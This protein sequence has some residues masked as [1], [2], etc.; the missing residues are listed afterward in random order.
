MEGALRRIDVAAIIAVVF[1][2]IVLGIFSAGHLK[3]RA[4]RARCAGNL[5]QIGLSLQLYSQDYT[6]LLPDCSRA[7]PQLAGAT[8]PLDLN[9]N[10]SSLLMAKGVTR[11]MFYCPANPQMNDDRHWNFWKQVPGP[12]R[13][14]GYG[15]LF[16]GVQQV[17]PTLWRA[18]FAG[19][20]GASPAEM[21]LGFDATASLNDDYTAITGIF[22]DRSNHM[23]KQDPLGGNM[24]FL[25][26]HTQ[27]RDFSDMEVRFRTIGPGGPISWNF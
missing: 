21:E 18:D 1:V 25:D 3:E 14:M 2:L 12:I 9:T 24:L 17:P 16:K 10:L 23:R 7:N 8:W 4:L 27:W 26:G 5:K 22:V 15:M 19:K 13:V 20:N 6:G 11:P